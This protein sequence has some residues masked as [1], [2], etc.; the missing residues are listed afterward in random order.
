MS[1]NWSPDSWQEKPLAQSVDYPDQALLGQ[2]LAELAEIPPLVTVWEVDALKQQ[3]A[4]AQQGERFLLQGGDCSEQFDDCRPD[5]IAGKLKIDV[6][7]AK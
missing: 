5:P 6:L 1:T 2:T 3:L 7:D 4:E